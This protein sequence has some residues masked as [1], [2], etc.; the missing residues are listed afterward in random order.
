MKTNLTLILL[1]L[2]FSIFAQNTRQKGLDAIPQSVIEAQLEFLA[3]DWTEGRATG[4]R[5]AYMAADY[6]ASMFK[7]YGIKPY[8][9]VETIYPSRA[10]RMQGKQPI[11]KQSYFQNFALIESK[12]LDNQIFTISTGKG[13]TKQT[14]RFNYETDF[15]VRTSTYG[16]ELNKSAVFVGYGIKDDE[17]NH[18][19]F[20]G[21]DV[22]GKFIIRLS[23]YPG[24]NDT[25][26]V[27]YKK[28]NPDY[29]KNSWQKE[30]IKNTVAEELGVAGI[31]E[32]DMDNRYAEYWAK[33]IPMRYNS[34]NYE[35]DK[36]RDS[37]YNSR[38]SIPGKTVDG[39]LNTIYVSKRVGNL[40]LSETNYDLDDFVKQAEA[41]SY[42]LIQPKNTTVYLKTN[43]DTRV[44]NARN[45]VGVIEGKNTDEVIVIGAH[46]DHLGKYDGYIWNGADDNA[47]GTVGVMS[48]AKAMMATGEKPEKTIV[49]AAW[50]GEEK[51]LLGSRHFAENFDETKQ[52]ILNLNYDM[53]GR[54]DLKDTLGVQVRMTYSEGY[55]GL[56]KINQENND[57]YKLGLDVTYRPSGARGGSDHLP[58]ARKN[59]PYFYF[60]AGFREDYHQ[61]TDHIEKINFEKMT[62]IIH[63]GFL[64]IYDIAFGE[65][66]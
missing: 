50:T 31:I 40:L 15:S 38:L 13:D 51:G 49:F 54:D 55:A 44:I 35:G 27:A 25:N 58:F 7:L 39:G 29:G 45:V 46:Y 24:M 28:F 65:E 62:K 64:S 9:D 8:G 33:N 20:K 43:V 3:S 16:V 11:D 41:L 63:L 66:F 34:E 52:M 47:S 26:S 30:R 12:A 17:L 22:E 42:K 60:M 6:I 5:G 21:I 19:D 37:N 14:Y 48:I 1:L 61:P 2:G 53:I 36:P 18:N 4:E 59:I 32:V 23:G 10:E 57:E 56:E